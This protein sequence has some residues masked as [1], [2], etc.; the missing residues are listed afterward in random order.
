[1]TLFATQDP[2]ARRARPKGSYAEAPV[3][4]EDEDQGD[5]SDDQDVSMAEQPSEG[6]SGDE[7]GSHGGGSDDGSSEEGMRR[8]KRKAKATKEPS[9]PLWRSG[10]ARVSANQNLAGSVYFCRVMSQG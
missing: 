3:S 4:G 10:R 6:S 9:Q 1:M 2:P 8:S 7:E 5:P